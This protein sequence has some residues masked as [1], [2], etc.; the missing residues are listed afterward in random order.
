MDDIQKN[1]DELNNLDVSFFDISRIKELFEEIHK[2]NIHVDESNKLIDL[3]LEKLESKLCDITDKSLENKFYATITELKKIKQENIKLF[4]IGNNEEIIKN[5]I[6]NDKFDK[7]FKKIKN[8]FFRIKGT[9]SDEFIKF[10]HIYHDLFKSDMK[11]IINMFLND[12]IKNYYLDHQKIII[13]ID[14]F[15]YFIINSDAM[16]L[17]NDNYY[18]SLNNVKHIL[19]VKGNIQYINETGANISINTFEEYKEINN[20]ILNADNEVDKYILSL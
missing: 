10:F 18:E 2:H 7:I 15:V 5:N 19:Y 16:N 13:D 3:R 4:D 14:D 17:M 8:I 11:E 9:Y 1:R 6:D 20:E 12:D